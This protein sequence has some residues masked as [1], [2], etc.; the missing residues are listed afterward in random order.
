[1]IFGAHLIQYSTEPESDRAFLRDVLGFPQVDA[2]HGWLIFALPPAE[3]AF[4]PGKLDDGAELYLMTSDLAATVA[5][6]RSAGVSYTPPADASWG[7]VTRVTLPSGGTIG[8]YQP[9]HPMA[10]PGPDTQSPA[11]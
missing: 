1:M 7:R 2:G 3:M 9:A 4:H 8:L 11:T 10:I 5:R 6:L